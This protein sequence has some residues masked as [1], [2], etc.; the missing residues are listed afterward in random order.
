MLIEFRFWLRNSNLRKLL[1]TC[2]CN[3]ISQCYCSS[4][5]WNFRQIYHFLQIFSF[6]KLSDFILITLILFAIFQSICYFNR[7]YFGA[8]FLRTTNYEHFFF[9]FFFL[10][11]VV[12][13]WKMQKKRKSANDST[14]DDNINRITI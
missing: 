7:K 4:I 5:V 8:A 12:Y 14:M 1:V 3:F 9:Y 2:G 13:A 11:K 10:Q 6:I